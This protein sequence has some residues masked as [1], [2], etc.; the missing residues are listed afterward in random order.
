MKRNLL[1]LILVAGLPG[2]KDDE[3]IESVQYY[4]ENAEARTQMIEK[5]KEVSLSDY[6]TNCRN[7]NAA[8]A[9]IKSDET[10][11]FAKDLYGIEE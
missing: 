7:A 8:K 2:C 1:A 3:V 9:L 5:C 11:N 10:H 6:G 4:K